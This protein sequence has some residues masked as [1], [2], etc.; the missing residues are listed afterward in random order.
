LSN[1][2][3]LNQ[4][5]PVIWVYLFFLYFSFVY[6]MIIYISGLSHFGGLRQSLLMSVVWLIPVLLWPSKTKWITAVIGGVLWVASMAGLGYWTIYQ[7]DF[8]QSVIF[9]LFE[10]SLEEG[11][12][13]IYS[14]Y[15]WWHTLVFGIFSVIPYL[16][17]KR[18]VPLELPLASRCKFVVVFLLIFFWPLINGYLFKG[19]DFQESRYAQMLRMEPAAPWNLVVGYAKYRD[20]LKEMNNLLDENSKLP[21]IPGLIEENPDSNKTLVL[22]IGESTNRQ[23]MSLYGY[24]RKTTPMLGGIRDELFVFNDVVTPRPFT[25]EA[26]QQVLSFADQKDI[27]AYFTQHTLLNMMKQAGYDI[28]WIT[29]QQTQT[30]RNTM[31]TTFS[32][33]ADH[34]IYLNNNRLQNAGQYDETVIE[35]FR[36]ALS[37]TTS[38]KMIVIHLLG[39]HRKYDYRYPDSFNKFTNQQG[40]PSWVESRLVEEYNS[41]DNSILYNDYVVSS[42]IDELRKMNSD[43]ALVYFSDHGEEVYDTPGNLF[44]GRNEAK[45]TSAMYTVPFIVWASETYKRHNNTTLWSDYENR[46]YSTSDFIYTWADIAGLDFSLNNEKRSIVSD[47]YTKYPRWIGDPSRPNLLRRYNDV[48]RDNQS[49]AMSKS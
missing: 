26:L 35:P 4:K 42:L 19:L 31:L 48:I 17:W 24:S 39:T 1:S 8:S 11:G 12:E 13:F 3:S 14:Y 6:Q 37:S 45:P 32:Q 2:V 46:P 40:V 33:M 25:I 38:K 44:C 29:N 18:I 20:Q 43:S 49:I 5:H 10:S 36:N 15:R 21:P 30:Q 23:R 7:Q 27:G 16:L 22:V 34:Q 28:T 47:E 9:I 41:Y